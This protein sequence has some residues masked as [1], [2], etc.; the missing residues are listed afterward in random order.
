MRRVTQIVGDG[1]AE[2]VIHPGALYEGA[3]ARQ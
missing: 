2:R 3:Q 1:E